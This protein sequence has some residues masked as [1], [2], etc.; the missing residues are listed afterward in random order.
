MKRVIRDRS[1]YYKEVAFNAL[2]DINP[3]RLKL[4]ASVAIEFTS[5][6]YMVD[7][8]V[9]DLLHLDWDETDVVSRINGF[10]GKV[11][12]IK[13]ATQESATLRGEPATLISATLGEIGILKT[14]R[15]AVI[16]ANI[17]E[18][19]ATLVRTSIKHGKPYEVDL[20]IRAL[21]ALNGRIFGLQKEMSAVLEI[22]GHHFT[23][24][25]LDL[26]GYAS[27]SA[28][29]DSKFFRARLA[30]LR[31]RHSSRKFLPTIPKLEEERS[32][33]QNQRGSGR[34]PVRPPGGPFPQ[35]AQSQDRK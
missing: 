12:I 5:L 34:T 32:T 21:R 14:Y 17:H 2:R 10:D 30:R 3:T 7:F 11:G 27:A 8:A 24:W 16:H 19:R 9:R 22:M 23:E 15:D 1:R 26:E 6:E 20:S 28:I 4:I 18:P 35:T 29:T 31:K 33:P 13:S 25:D